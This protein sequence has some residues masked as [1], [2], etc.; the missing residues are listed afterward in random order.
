MATFH[1]HRWVEVDGGLLWDAVNAEVVFN[2]AELR[3]LRPPAGD[4]LTAAP[5][6][7]HPQIPACTQFRRFVGMFSGFT[8]SN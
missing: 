1:R 3:S 8:F 4:F 7:G 5:S 6:R 2:N